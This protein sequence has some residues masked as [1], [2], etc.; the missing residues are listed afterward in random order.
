M[1]SEEL[2]KKFQWAVEED[3]GAKISFEEASKILT[4]LTSYFDL[5]GKLYH[6]IKTKNDEHNK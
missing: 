6:T 3:Y 1:L 2:I 5:L 4:G